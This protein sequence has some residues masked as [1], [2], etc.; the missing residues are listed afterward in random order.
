MNTELNNRAKFTVDE[1]KTEASK[2]KEENEK[3]RGHI[4]E[5]INDN[6]RLG[7]SLLNVNQQSKSLET[8]LGSLRKK[9]E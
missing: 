6:K 8:D 4:D 2:I 3:R 9:H 7:D 5:L 1:L